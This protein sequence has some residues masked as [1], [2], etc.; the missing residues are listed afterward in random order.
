[1]M[2]LLQ[3]LLFSKES[4]RPMNFS[5]MSFYRYEEIC[6]QSRSVSVLP[7]RWDEWMLVKIFL[8]KWLRNDF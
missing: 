8:T 5:F 2:V 4:P 7:N 6:Y 1:M 3:F